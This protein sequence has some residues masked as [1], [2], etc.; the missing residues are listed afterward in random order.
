MLERI[1][2]NGLKRGENGRVGEDEIG[3]VRGT[4]ILF[5]QQ[6]PPTKALGENF[7][8]DTESRPYP[9]GWDNAG[10]NVPVHACATQAE[11]PGYFCN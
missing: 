7:R 8:V 10:V 3:L 11:K 1:N 9:D 5:L 4:T 2:R 6:S